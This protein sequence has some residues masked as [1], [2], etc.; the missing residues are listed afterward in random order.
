MLEGDGSGGMLELGGDTAFVDVLRPPPRLF[1]FGAGD[2]ARPL[3]SLAA[4]AG[5]E[6]T[7]VDHRP[8]YLTPERFPR[9][10]GVA[11]KRP[12]GA[13]ATTSATTSDR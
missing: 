13:A 12:L 8:A 9:R 7:V 3:A 1:I 10:P 2:D 11:R 5:F 6:V 4:Q